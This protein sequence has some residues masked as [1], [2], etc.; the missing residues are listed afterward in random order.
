M[1]SS[2]KLF[3]LAKE[4]IK[5]DENCADA[6][7]CA[8][9]VCMSLGRYEDASEYYQKAVNWAIRTMEIAFSASAMHRQA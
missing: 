1:V 9:N 5:L 2:K 3:T 8:A 4:A 6:Y 7:Q